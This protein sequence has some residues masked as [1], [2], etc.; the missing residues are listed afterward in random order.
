MSIGFLQTTML[1]GLAGLAIPVLIHLWNRRRP[2]VIDWGAMQFLELHPARRRRLV[3][4]E[5]LLLLARLALVALVV[6]GL[7]APVARGPVV[8]A[9]AEPP[10][11][12]VYVLDASASMAR[13]DVDPSPWARALETLRAEVR[14][15]RP[16]DRWG[17]VLA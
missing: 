1:L 8:T 2:E 6:G 13:A 15:M 17:L 7:A 10:R 11:D 3:L 12:V 4:E 16:G 9:L 5:W 14:G